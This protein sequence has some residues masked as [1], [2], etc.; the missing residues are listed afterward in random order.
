M[1]LHLHQVDDSTDVQDARQAVEVPHGWDI[2]PG[3]ADD[4]RVCGAHAW[5]AQ[6][7]VVASGDCY[8][9]GMCSNP[10]H[11]GKRAA[12]SC[13][14]C[15]TSSRQIQKHQ[16]NSNRRPRASSDVAPHAR[17]QAKEAQAAL[18]SGTGP[19]CAPPTAASTVCCAS[20][21]DASQPPAPPPAP[22]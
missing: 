17:A 6:F 20:V 15:G 4:A 7:L 10:N 2:A 21:R 14:R 3:D 9:T 22:Q 11:I 8:G 13:G 1:T 16:Q 19:G 5:Q 18:C 12:C